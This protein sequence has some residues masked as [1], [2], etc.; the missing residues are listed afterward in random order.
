MSWRAEK[1]LLHSCSS[2][3]WRCNEVEMVMLWFDGWGLQAHLTLTVNYALCICVLITRNF[4]ILSL[5]ASLNGI[6]CRDSILGSEFGRWNIN[7]VRTQLSLVWKIWDHRLL[8][9]I[10]VHWWVGVAGHLA[11]WLSRISLL[12]FL[13]LSL[14]SSFHRA[15]TC[16]SYCRR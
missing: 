16:R 12:R 4:K 9:V 13:L 7:L 5:G 10:V 8:W 15:Q 3:E 2:S 11:E 14:Q 6:W 1:W